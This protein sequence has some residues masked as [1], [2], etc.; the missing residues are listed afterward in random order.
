MLDTKLVVIRIHVQD[1]VSLTDFLNIYLFL[2][3]NVIFFIFFKN[4]VNLHSLKLY[5]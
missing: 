3:D 1:T 5:K 4:Q 2:N